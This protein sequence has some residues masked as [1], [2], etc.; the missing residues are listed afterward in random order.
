MKNYIDLE[1]FISQQTV[2]VR[3]LL[4]YLRQLMSVAHVQ[5]R[6][7]LLYNTLFFTCGDYVCYVGKIHAVKGVEIGFPKGFWL[8]DAAGVLEANNRKWIRGIT[9]KNLSDFQTREEVFLEI[10]QQAIL[11]NESKPNTTF[12]QMIGQQRKKEA[13]KIKN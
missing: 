7:R 10:V 4:Y 12:G 1:D 9:F 8:E 6:E 3:H 11:L 5:M 13:L 2:E